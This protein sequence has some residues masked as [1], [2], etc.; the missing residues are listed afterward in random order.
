MSLLS[1]FKQ[2]AASSKL[3]DVQGEINQCSL[4]EDG[5]WG[6]DIK[7]SEPISYEAF[8]YVEERI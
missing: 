8:D 4:D 2:I 6:S 5:G 3:E 7:Q 1:S